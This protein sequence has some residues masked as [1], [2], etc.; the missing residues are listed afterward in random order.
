MTALQ[1]YRDDGRV[2]EWVGRAVGGAIRIDAALLTVLGAIPLAAVLAAADRPLRTYALIPATA[3]LVLLGGVGSRD[4]SA[5]ALAWAIPPLLRTFEYGFLIALTRLADPDAM[6]LCFA[7]LVVLAFHHYDTIYRLRHQRVAPAARVRAAGGGWDG[8]L[9]VAAALVPL[10]AVGV[11][12][13]VGTAALAVAYVGE[14]VSSWVRFGRAER[15]APY[16]GDEVLE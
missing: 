14:C 13:A 9:L 12:L 10:E 15:A 16:E 11:G 1:A 3:A 4:P 7:L 2:A 8:R 5:G 6:P